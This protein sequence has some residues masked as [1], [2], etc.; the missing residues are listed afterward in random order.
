MLPGWFIDPKSDRRWSGKLDSVARAT[1]LRSPDKED[2]L[3]AGLLGG[4]TEY[5]LCRGD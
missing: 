2:K 5:G 3:P 4:I 1:S